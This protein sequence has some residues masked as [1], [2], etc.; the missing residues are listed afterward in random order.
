MFSKIGPKDWAQLYT[1]LQG[2]LPSPL[3]MDIASKSLDEGNSPSLL[4]FLFVL[5]FY[6]AVN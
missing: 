1:A 4:G 2:V 3:A 6:F 5:F